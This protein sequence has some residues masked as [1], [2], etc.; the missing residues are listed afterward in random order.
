[1]P[2]SDHLHHVPG[3]NKAN[4]CQIWQCKGCLWLPLC[5]SMQV[6]FGHQNSVY[7]FGYFVYYYYCGH[8]HSVYCITFLLSVSFLH[9]YC[10]GQSV[11]YSVF[12]VPFIQSYS[13][14]HHSVYCVV[15]TSHFQ[16]TFVSPFLRDIL[17]T[18]LDLFIELI[19]IPLLFWLPPFLNC[20]L[21]FVLFWV[22]FQHHKDFHNLHHVYRC[23]LCTLLV[24]TI[25]DRCV[26]VLF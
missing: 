18:K 21:F 20:Q 22:Y 4:L 10:F 9:T 14:L 6:Y 13:G 19:W 12:L 7:C 1:M 25:I 17:W 23:L 3:M 5:G 16:G 2:G 15:L 24:S 11:Y 26:L 8:H